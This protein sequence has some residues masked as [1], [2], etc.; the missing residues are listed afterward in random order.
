MTIDIYYVYR[1]I[2]LDTHKPFYV[3]KGHGNR[4]YD[5]RRRNK[6]H[7]NIVKK[8]GCKV[9][10]I[11]QDQSE[12]NSLILESKIIKLYKSFG[13]CEAN[14]CL[15]GNGS[16][17]YKHTELWKKS[18][19]ELKKGSN[20]YWF[21]KKIPDSAKIKLR[22][23]NLGKMIGGNNLG[24]LNNSWKGYVYTPFGIFETCVSAS[25]ILRINYTTLNRRLKNPK[26]VEWYFKR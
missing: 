19:S 8:Y 23:I 20:A 17:G 22:N 1:H 5:L 15:G 11:F 6:Y 21:G 4:A 9:E 7:K 25:K 3:G 2:R 10:I 14:F 24:K 12:S 16:V 18:M 26:C 13:L